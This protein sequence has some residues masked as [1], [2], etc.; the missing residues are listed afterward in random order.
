MIIIT[1]VRLGSSGVRSYENIEQVRYHVVHVDPATLPAGSA[2]QVETGEGDVAEMVWEIKQGTRV[3]S[4]GTP[5]AEVEIF[6]LRNRE[7][8]RTKADDTATN[9]LLS[10]PLF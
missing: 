7:Y 1:H 4:E 3:C 5:K 10:L 8:I 2:V 9:N 6:A